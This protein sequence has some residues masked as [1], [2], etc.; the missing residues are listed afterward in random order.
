MTTT[1]TKD[2]VLVKEPGR[3]QAWLKWLLRF[4]RKKPLGAI[5]GAIVFM[6]VVTAL[7]APFVSP[8]DPIDDDYEVKLTGP[9]TSHFFGTDQFG[10]DLFSRVLHGA[11][12]SLYVG[13]FSVALG[14]GAGTLLGLTSGYLGGKVDLLIQ[15]CADVLMA[16]PFL[17]LAMAIVATLGASINNVVLAIAIVQAPNVSRVVRS[18]VLSLKENQYIEAARA[19]GGSTPR[20]MLRHIAPNVMAPVIILATAGLGSAILVEASLSFLGVG[21]P[22]P[23]PSWGGELSKAGRQF[24]Q[25]A[26]WLAIFPGIAIT[27]AV[28]GFNLV[29]DALRDVLDPRLR[30]T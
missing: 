29:G 4:A 7:A 6:M 11:R 8:Y 17:V 3:G 16:F 26:P 30:G 13:L 12:V 1:T 22:P 19:I 10:R 5:G 15:R 2:R 20:I 23:L 25:V 9:S 24:A 18:S 27:L 14:T 28:F 21:T